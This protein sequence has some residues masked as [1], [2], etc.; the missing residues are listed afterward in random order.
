MRLCLL[1]A[2][3]YPPYSKWLGS[4]FARLPGIETVAGALRGALAAG[5]WREREARLCRAYEEVAVRTNETGLATRVDPTVREFHKRPFLVLDAAR[6]ATAL[7]A[8]I[9]NPWLRKLPPIGAVDQ[10]V[11]STDLLSGT[12]RTRA[13]VAAALS[14]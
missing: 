2:R 11:D 6:F 7:Y 9:G 4:A 12:A 1:L 5:D 8:A 3:H 10:Y 14:G 13:V